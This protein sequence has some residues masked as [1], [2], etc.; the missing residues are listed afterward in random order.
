MKTDQLPCSYTALKSLVKHLEVSDPGMASLF[1]F[2]C[3]MHGKWEGKKGMLGMG[4]LVEALLV[5]GDK[6]Q[7]FLPLGPQESSFPRGYWE[8]LECDEEDL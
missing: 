2:L 8:G 5:P 3:G 6:E 4:L 7:P 1:P